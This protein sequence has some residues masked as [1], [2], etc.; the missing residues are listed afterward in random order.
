MPKVEI[1][2]RIVHDQEVNRARHCPQDPFLI[3]TKSPSS[4][5]LVFNWSKHPSKPKDSSCNPQVGWGMPA[6]SG[7]SE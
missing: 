1:T 2:V 4:D 5:V 6:S 3:A 7:R